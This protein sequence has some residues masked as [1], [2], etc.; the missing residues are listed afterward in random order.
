MCNLC[1]NGLGFQCAE[2]GCRICKDVKEEHGLLLPPEPAIDNNGEFLCPACYRE[3]IVL[4][5]AIAN[6]DEHMAANE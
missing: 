3:W 6:D 1:I 5:K 2:C 4:L